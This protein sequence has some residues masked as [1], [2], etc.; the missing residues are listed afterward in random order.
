MSQSIPMTADEMANL[1]R[2]HSR[3]KGAIAGNLETWLTDPETLPR[4]L[5]LIPAPAAGETKLLELG[6]YQPSVGY[7]FKLGWKEVVGVF[8]DDGEG[9]QED[10]Y[11][12][13]NGV[14]ARLIMADAETQELPVPAGWADVVVMME[15]LEH[16]GVDPMHA[17]WEVNRVLR[18][19]GRLI[20]STPNG[21]SWHCAR[22]ITRG[23]AAWGGMEFTGFSTNR[24]N[25]LYDAMELPVILHQAGFQVM[26]CKSR[27]YGR[28]KLHWHDR[29]FRLFLGVVDCLGYVVSGRRREREQFLVAQATK[30][31]SP[32]ER[33]PRSLYLTA[34]EWPGIT[35]QREK[36]LTQR[37]GG[38]S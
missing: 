30:Q 29:I 27:D 35:E 17:L 22:R 38:P 5:E 2:A 31:D 21:S 11:S 9:T 24:H 25:R 4:Y 1:F 20:L 34:V 13:E 6:C 32:K 8:K 7:Y 23:Q 37:S 14:S 12:G 26:H 19:G 15:V 16:L 28:G 10:F 36:L 18:P 33:F 3:L